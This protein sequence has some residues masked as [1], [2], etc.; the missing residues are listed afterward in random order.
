MTDSGVMW[1]RRLREQVQT[2]LPETLDGLK[3]TQHPKLDRNG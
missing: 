1:P 2:A 3:R